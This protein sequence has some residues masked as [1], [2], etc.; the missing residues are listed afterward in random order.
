MPGSSTLSVRQERLPCL[1]MK[2]S[3]LGI[4]WFVEVSSMYLGGLCVG[5]SGLYFHVGRA[6]LSEFNICSFLLRA[7]QRI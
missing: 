5:R 4:E 1:D 3:S 6:I 7:F 2:Y